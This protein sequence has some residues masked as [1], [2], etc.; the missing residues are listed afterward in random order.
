MQKGAKQFL[1]D[2]FGA[3]VSAYASGGTEE[4]NTTMSKDF[5]KD[6]FAS[7]TQQQ[8]D[9]CWRDWYSSEPLKWDFFRQTVEG[10]DQLR[11]RMA[12]ALQQILVVSERSINGTYGLRDYFQTIR[13]N[14]FGNYR[15]LLKEV[16]LHPV[17]GA[18]LNMVNNEPIDPNENY[19]RE[20][21]QLFSIGTCELNLDGT[22]KTGKCV[23]TYSNTVVRDYAYA[24]SG[25]TYPAGGKNAYCTFGPVAGDCG[26]WQNNEYLKGRMIAVAAKHDNKDRTLLSGVKVPATRT[27]AQALEA[28]LDSVMNHPNVAPFISKQLI[29]HFVTSNPSPAYV[30]RVA[31][32]FNAGSYNGI[33]GGTGRGDL[34][35]TIAAI[36]LDTEARD[37]AKTA[38]PTFGKLRE[39]VVFMAGAI[40]AFSGSTDGVPLGLYWFG[41]ALGQSVFSPPSVFN[42]Y[43]PDYPLPGRSDLMAPQFGITNASTLMARANFANSLIFWWFNKGVEY[44]PD[45]TVAGK[46]T[47]LNYAPFEA[48]ADDIPAL[49]KRLNDLL[50]DGRLTAAEQTFLVDAAKTWDATHTWLANENTNYRKERVKMIAYLIFSSP[51]YQVQR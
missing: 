17:M 43:P 30:Q 47:K 48:A 26:G 10:Q 16:T 25:Y 19:A 5:C 3:P 15:T 8:K 32:A 34:Q 14:A 13:N 28:V 38:D 39:P 12:W 22:L 35:A 51:Q 23:A 37:P 20:L 40:R 29:Q 36:L 9:N 42:Y 6:K 11:Q 7:G 24:L 33:S 46:G 4:V 45:T 44:K 2:Q 31:Q 27:P 1:L 21:L 41:D 50:V 18:Y 49:V